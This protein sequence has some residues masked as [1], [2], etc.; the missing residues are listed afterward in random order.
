LKDFAQELE[1]VGIHTVVVEP[2]MIRTSFTD[3]DATEIAA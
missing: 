3:F 1:L 2:G